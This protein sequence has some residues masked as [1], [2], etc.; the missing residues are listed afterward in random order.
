MRFVCAVALLVGL[1]SLAGGD[2]ERGKFPVA[3]NPD[4][5]F[6]KADIYNLTQTSQL[7]KLRPDAPLDPSTR[8]AF[9]SSTVHQE[10]SLNF[11]RS[12]RLHGAVTKLDQRQRFGQYFDFFWRAKRSADVTVRFEYKQEKLRAFVQAKEQVYQ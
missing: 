5:E 2:S 6:R 8:A 3:L 7:R 1:G 4:F 9:R 10:A 11:E 12:Y